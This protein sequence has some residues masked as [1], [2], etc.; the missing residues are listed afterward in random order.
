[1][2]TEYG[3]IGEVRWLNADQVT[4]YDENGNPVLCKCGKKAGAC[5]MGKDSF[6]AWCSECCPMNKHEEKMVYLPNKNKNSRVLSDQWIVK[7]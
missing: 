3:S 7:I 2:E 5:A 4:L 1:M 6:L